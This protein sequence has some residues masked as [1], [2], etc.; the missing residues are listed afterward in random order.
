MIR[1]ILSTITFLLISCNTTNKD[2]KTI[3]IGA[4]T[5]PCNT[6]VMESQCLQVK[7]AK[8]KKDWEHFYSNIEG[9]KYEQGNEYELIIKEE[10]V[11]NP[12][13]DGSSIKYTLIK[14]ISKNKVANN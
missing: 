2:E 3:F 12:P 13:A 11:E 6:G 4:E 5:K 14:E 7:W 10:K 1:I 9:F 8:N